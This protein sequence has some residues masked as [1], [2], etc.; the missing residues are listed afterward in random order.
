ME[1][2]VHVVE[3][4]FARGKSQGSKKMLVSFL[5]MSVVMMAFVAQATAS[6]IFKRDDGGKNK[7]ATPHVIIALSVL[8]ALF[9]S[10]LS[11]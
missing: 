2:T 7:L 6:V 9:I 3:V 5:H 4:I 8:G 11:T 1:C 10:K